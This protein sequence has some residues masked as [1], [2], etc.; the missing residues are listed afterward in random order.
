MGS[1]KAFNLDEKMIASL[2][3]QGYVSSSPIQSLVIPKA[4]QGLN[5]VVKSETGSGKTHAYL[6]PL[7]AKLNR[8]DRANLYG[9]IIAP[10]NELARQ[11]F[12][13][14]RMFKREYGDI[15]VRLLT[16]ETSEKENISG[17]S[18]TPNLVIGTPG[19]LSSLFKK[20][21][22]NAKNVNILILD[23]ADMLLELGYF[24]DIN[25]LVNQFN[26]PQIMIF[27]A[28][29][30]DNLR[31][32]INK[33]IGADYEITS[34]KKQDTGGGV[35]HY[36]VDIHHQDLNEA[37]LSFI[38]IKNPYFLLIFASNKNEVNSL[39]NYL[40]KLKYSV[41]M[42][43]G[44][45]TDRERRATIKR[46]NNDEYQI[47]VASDLVSRGMDF[48]NVS[49]VLSINL[50]SD[51]TYYH[52]RAGRTGRFDKVGNSYVFYNVSETKRVSALIN[53][54]VKFNYLSLK[55]NELTQGKAF[56]KEFKRN[57]KIDENLLRDIKKAK[58]E[59][60]G[61]KVKPNYKKKVK[62]AINKV[63]QK[64]KREVIRQDIRR[65]RV[66]RYKQEAKNK[67]YE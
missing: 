59:S 17:L 65:Q 13:F 42:I 62:L 34:D 37:A 47:V 67:N 20:G 28:T 25:Y 56:V 40:K 11:I 19:R 16:S 1:F 38:K 57:K 9:V 29:I 8:L 61:N 24:N 10:T 30:K 26:K 21:H 3:R 41:T 7:L 46:I 39:Y 22:L 54:G 23:E 49:D 15:K 35:T 33:Y 48:K 6:I 36:L 55:N 18:I 27:S 52:H 63:K 53:Q 45:L 51:L 66:E 2:L 64:H 12:T 14:T 43:T 31:N 4:L 44:D 60:K 32:Q 58:Y 5:L 50:P